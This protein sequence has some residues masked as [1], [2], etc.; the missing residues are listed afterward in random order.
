MT[1]CPNCG[2]PVTGRRCE[3]CGTV[4]RL[5]WPE[6]TFVNTWD[7]CGGGG[8]SGKATYLMSATMAFREEMASAIYS[9]MSF[10]LRDTLQLHQ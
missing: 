9:A 1:N 8:G 2:A 6:A 10:L 5:N 7:P 4:F 3:Y